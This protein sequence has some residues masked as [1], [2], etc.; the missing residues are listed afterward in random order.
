[1]NRPKRIVVAESLADLLEHL[2]LCRGGGALVTVARMPREPLD[3]FACRVADRLVA[4][5]LSRARIDRGAYVCGSDDDPLDGRSAIATLLVA[6]I[7]MG[8]GGSLILAEPRG[9]RRGRHVQIGHFAEEL[10]TELAESVAIRIVGPTAAA[11]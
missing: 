11:V 4:D 5:D 3:D 1:M 8:G 9:E 6:A 7:A 2:A 10:A